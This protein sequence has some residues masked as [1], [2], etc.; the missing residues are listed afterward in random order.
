MTTHNLTNLLDDQD[1]QE[2]TIIETSNYFEIEEFIEKYKTNK[3]GNFLLNL[4]I[5]SLPS[6]LDNIKTLLDRIESIPKLKLSF[7]NLQETWLEELQEPSIHFPNYKIEFKHKINGKIGGG[8]AILIG[9][10][11]YYKWHHLLVY[12]PE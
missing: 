2:P 3:S 5:Q 6:K 12:I 11:N 4:N 9:N 1:K 7:I 8:L 10:H